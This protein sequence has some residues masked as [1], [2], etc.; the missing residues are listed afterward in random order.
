MASHNI[1]A[2]LGLVL[3]EKPAPSSRRTWNWRH[4]GLQ[5]I[6]LL[7]VAACFFFIVHNTLSNMGRLGIHAG[8]GFLSQPARFDISQHFIPY[9]GNSTY[10]MV[11]VVALLN[12][13]TLALICMALSTVLGLIIGLCRLSSN[14]LLAFVA[15]AYVNI[16]RNIPLL[17]QLFFWY[18]VTIGT[19]PMVRQSIELPGDIFLNRRGVFM[20][21][22]V[23]QVSFGAFLIAFATGLAIWWFAGRHA[24][25]HRIRTGQN[26]ALRWLGPAATVLLPALVWIGLGTPFVLDLPAPKGLNMAG[27]MALLPEFAA[28]IIALTVYNAAFI[29][30]LVRGG[31]QSVAK[32]Q[33]EAATALGLR[34]AQIYSKITVPQAL[35]AIIPP[36]STQYLQLLKAT[37]LG[38]AIAYPDLM[39]VFAGTALAQTSQPIEIMGITMLSYLVLGL[40]IAAVTNLVNR[41]VQIKER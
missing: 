4:L 23:P 28:M 36:L 38:A 20:P 32:G 25:R 15:T 7:I 37:S 24:R 12:T 8:L 29:A 16:L 13:V 19:L 1:N 6:V 9:D 33:T 35:R 40:C 34:S 2:E 3:A 39:L 31:V 17:L 41:R 18:F 21:A 30:E 14:P 22:P 26:S 27:G 5:A 10:A 11:F